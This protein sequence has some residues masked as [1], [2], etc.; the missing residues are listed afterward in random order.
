MVRTIVLAFIWFYQKCIS[1]LLPPRCRFYPTC[2]E[3]G[4]QAVE[5]YG[6]GRGLVML[7]KRLMR[8]HPWGA[9]GYDPVK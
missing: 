6:V 3:Y 8:C 1:P 7:A 2:S 5:K 4:R 9:G